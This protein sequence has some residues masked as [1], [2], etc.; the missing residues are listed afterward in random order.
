MIGS[1]QSSHGAYMIHGKRKAHVSV[2]NVR[3]V[4]DH[5]GPM[6]KQNMKKSWVIYVPQ[7]WPL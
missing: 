2:T 7:L 1:V 6:R 3:A 4:M 5:I